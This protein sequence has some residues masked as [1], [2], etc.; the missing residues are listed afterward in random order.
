MMATVIEKDDSDAEPQEID[1]RLF[2]CMVC[3]AVFNELETW[4]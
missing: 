3:G 1:T 4:D 2:S